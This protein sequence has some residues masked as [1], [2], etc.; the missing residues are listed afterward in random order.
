MFIGSVPKDVMMQM[1]SIVDFENYEN[2]FILC[3]GS[4][5]VDSNIS[6]TYQKLKVH[7]NDVNVLSVSIGKL[8]VGETINV[9]FVN[10]LF[11]VEEYLGG[12]ESYSF[13][14]RVAA[15]AA[16]MQVAKFSS[17]NEYNQIHQKHIIQNFAKFHQKAKSSIQKLLEKLPIA[18]FTPGDF[19]EQAKKAKPGTDIVIGFPPTYKGGYE[20]IFKFVD[21]NIE[22]TPPEYAIFDP[23][24]L[25]DILLDMSGRG[26]SYCVYSDQQIDKLTC[27][28]K[29]LSTS[30]KPIYLYVNN[31]DKSS[32]R[33]KNQNSRQFK[34]QP[35]DPAEATPDSVVQ[36]ARMDAAQMNFLKNVYLA[37][38][39]NHV[40]RM[41]NYCVFVDGKLAGGII[42]ALSKY[43]DI[44]SLYVLSDFS[45]SRSNKLSKLI[46]MIATSRD[47]VAE[48]E[49]KTLLKFKSVF[50]T[51]FTDKPVSMK[52]R[53]IWDLYARKEGFLNYQSKIRQQ[54]P[55]QIYNE[56][57]IKYY[58]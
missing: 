53:G 46:A 27:G 8:A 56:W 33:K 6:S 50:T 12:L 28:G 47:I 44:E 25:V 11:F 2:A 18:T 49:R 14:D 1:H 31:I 38:R 26:I 37:K 48:I 40:A 29:F 10:K 35:F 15:I 9:S 30:N 7:S 32:F 39:I 19:I 58:K 54:S 55:Q 52:C 3:S 16:S 43:G 51:V 34:Y 21:Q 17:N 23:K 13:I 5:R 22:W 4:F 41:F 36:V 42:M 24:T 45:V 57:F 20:R